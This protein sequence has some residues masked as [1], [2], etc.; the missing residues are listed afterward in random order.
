MSERKREGEGELGGGV[1]EAYGLF[2]CPSLPST[3]VLCQC[4]SPDNSLS[5]RSHIQSCPCHTVRN[6]HT[7]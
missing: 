7:I 3:L 4:S 2:Q 5:T 1:D 6:E